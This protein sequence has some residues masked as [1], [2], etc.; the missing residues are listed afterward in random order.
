M[1]AVVLSELKNH[2]IETPLDTS[3]INHKNKER[4]KFWRTHTVGDDNIYEIINSELGETNLSL[5]GFFQNELIIEYFDRYNY[6]FFQ[7]YEYNDGVF[8]HVRLGDLLDMRHGIKRYCDLEYYELVLDS[9]KVENGYISSDSLE[10]KTVRT[11]IEKYNLTPFIGDEDSTIKFGCSFKNKVLSLG[12][13]SWWIGYLGCQENVN[14][15]DSKKNDI[16]HGNIQT[17]TH[18]NLF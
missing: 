11:L 8:V 5:N 17:K 9:I 16:W 7:P 1:T 6:L 13:F 12:T 14:F 18:W 10:H 4:N 2:S 3:I 15:P